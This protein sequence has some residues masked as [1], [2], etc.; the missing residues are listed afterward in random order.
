METVTHNLT[1]VLIQIL[2]FKFFQLPYNI[3][4]TI[5]FAFLSHFLIDALSKITYH[6]PEA[7]KE[8]KFWV[9]WHI[10]IFVIS[11]LSFGIFILEFWIG[12]LFAN[13]VDIWDWLIIRNIQ[14]YKKKKNPDSNWCQGCYMHPIADKIRNKL[15]FFL[16]N[17]NYKHVGIIPEIILI[18]I[19]SIF[20]VFFLV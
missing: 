3:F 15:F 2:C 6:T 20:I 5:I 1:G 7:R 16:P 12:M 18:T 17:L 14:T 13:L 11:I 10:I 9:I 4:F 19:L 8:D